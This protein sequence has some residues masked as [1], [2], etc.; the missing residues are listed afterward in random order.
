MK[1]NVVVRSERVEVRDTLIMRPVKGPLK[2]YDQGRGL[3][4]STVS[5]AGEIDGSRCKVYGPVTGGTVVGTVE[6]A[7][8]GVPYKTTTIRCIE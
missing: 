6:M 3:T 5:V 2:M 7:Y 1:K 4:M 8:S